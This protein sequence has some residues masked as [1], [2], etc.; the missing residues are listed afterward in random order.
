[1]GGRGFEQGL[2]Y[3]TA[4]IR[5]TLASEDYALGLAASHSRVMTDTY[6]HVVPGLG[7]AAVGAVDEALGYG[8]S[9]K[10]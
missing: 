3:E 9:R 8:G 5:A 4:A 7:C 1:M 10:G 2:R 6:S